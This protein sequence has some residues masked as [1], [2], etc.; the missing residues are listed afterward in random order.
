MILPSLLHG[1]NPLRSSLTTNRI[2]KWDDVFF[3]CRVRERDGLLLEGK[4]VYRPDWTAPCRQRDEEVGFSHLTSHTIS[5][6]NDR[7]ICLNRQKEE[8]AAES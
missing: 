2:N 6:Y 3:T 7:A 1:E 4:V 5:P 8:D